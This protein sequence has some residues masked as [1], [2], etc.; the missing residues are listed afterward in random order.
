MENFDRR[1]NRPYYRL[2]HHRVGEVSAVPAWKLNP[3]TS[4][5]PLNF[6]ETIILRHFNSPLFDITTQNDVINLVNDLT[7][8]NANNFKPFRIDLTDAWNHYYE[9]NRATA[10]LIFNMSPPRTRNSL[11]CTKI[12]TSLIFQQTYTVQMI[13]MINPFQ[14]DYDNTLANTLLSNKITDITQNAAHQQ[15]LL[16]HI[17][18]FPNTVES[19]IIAFMTGFF[20]YIHDPLGPCFTFITDLHDIVE[21]ILPESEPAK[22]IVYWFNSPL[23]LKAR[24]NFCSTIAQVFKYVNNPLKPYLY[25]KYDHDLQYIIDSPTSS[26]IYDSRE[27]KFLDAPRAG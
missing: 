16:T 18:S 7:T 19:R 17:N 22:Y 23:L 14:R 12:A 24:F 8:S 21:D 26:A 15:Q 20:D 27:Y 13:A 4:A 25:D 11:K 6:R 1:Y 5:L 10:Q 9:F 3:L 2:P